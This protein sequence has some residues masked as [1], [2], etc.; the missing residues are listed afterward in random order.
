MSWVHAV[1]DGMALCVTSNS[2]AHDV[3]RDI[4]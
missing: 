1:I 2:P 3:R 4:G